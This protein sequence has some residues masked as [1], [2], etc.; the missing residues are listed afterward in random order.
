MPIL[1]A[2][3]GGGS[4]DIKK[5]DNFLASG[6]W[7]CSNIRVV[8]SRFMA[9]HYETFDTVTVSEDLYTFCHFLRYGRKDWAA[10][11]QHASVTIFCTTYSISCGTCIC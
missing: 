2:V 6:A 4:L 3:G 1:E 5:L 7:G 9:D 10:N 11:L 8:R